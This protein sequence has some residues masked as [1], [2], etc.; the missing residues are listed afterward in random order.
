M[1]TALI[2]DCHGLGWM[3]AYTIGHLS[4]KGTNTGIMYGFF[5]Q[6]LK[7]CSYVQPDIFIF[8]WDSRKS[9]R[10][11]L[12][13]E[14]KAKRRSQGTQQEEILRKQVAIQLNKL[15]TQILPDLGFNNQFQYT[16]YEADDIIASVIHTY[17]FDQAVIV[18]TDNDML[19]LLSEKVSI[20][21]GKKD[22]IYTVDDFIRVYDGLTPDKWAEVKT[23][24]GCSSDNVPGIKGIGEATAVKY[25]LGTM[26]PSG[27]KY[28]S[29]IN[30]IGS[31]DYER[32]KKLVTLPYKQLDFEL[33][34]DQISLKKFNKLCREA[35]FSS[36]LRKGVQLKFIKNMGMQ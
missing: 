4:H 32:D 31:P 35:G 6:L 7:A 9:H 15:R 16:G 20:Y 10:K 22:F 21:N 2:V 30:A 13:P 33:H 18:S 27:K 19:Q 17:D 12:Y 28:E 8:A 24:A 3:A 26:K 11:R 29:I 34:N 5:K 23:L 36:F 14:Y 1:P 25:L